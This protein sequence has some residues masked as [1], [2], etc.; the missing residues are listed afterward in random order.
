MQANHP[1]D[2]PK[3]WDNYVTQ[4]LSRG[5]FGGGP[6]VM[7]SGNSCG[8]DELGMLLRRLLRIFSIIILAMLVILLVAVVG[9]FDL[10]PRR[11][12]PVLRG[13]ERVGQVC[14]ACQHLP[15]AR[16]EVGCSTPSALENRSMK[17]DDLTHYAAICRVKR[18][19]RPYLEAIL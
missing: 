6:I 1:F 14:T 7:R 3:E 11:L 19:I 15:A 17:V 9:L 4:V 10:R 12:L 16:E 2:T 5:I 8:L 13:V 18:T